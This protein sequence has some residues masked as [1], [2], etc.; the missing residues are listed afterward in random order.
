MMDYNILKMSEDHIE[1]VAEIEKL[2]FSTPWSE[3]ALREELNNSRAYFLVCA[4][5]GRIAGYIGSHNV[6]GEVYITNVA[7]H[8]DYRRKGIG[9]MLV[10]SLVEAF[11]C[12]GEFVTLEVRESNSPAQNLYSK[13]GFCQVGKRKS[14]YE[15]PTE[16]AVLMTYRYNKEGI[17]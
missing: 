9:E 13:L 4:D 15:H 7:V 6:L 5:G 12:D 16:D 10:K 17:E 1:A 2:C 14:F 11:S 8:P 3:N